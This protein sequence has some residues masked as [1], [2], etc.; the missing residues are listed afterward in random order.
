MDS[1]WSSSQCNT[2]AQCGANKAS[3]HFALRG[4]C[5]EKLRAPAAKCAL[6]NLAQAQP[7]ILCAPKVSVPQNMAAGK[8][9][10]HFDFGIVVS[11]IGS[12]QTDRGPP[13]S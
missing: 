4:K 10:A 12:P 13:L 8:T 2:Q 11:S 7:A 6:R 3:R 9:P 5:G 1:S